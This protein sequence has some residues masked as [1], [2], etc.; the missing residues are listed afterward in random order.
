MP[1]FKHLSD[2]EQDALFD[3]LR[4]LAGASPSAPQPAQVSETSLRI[5]EHVIEGNCR[6]C[7]DATGPGAGQAGLMAGRIPSL[8]TM[9]D[10][11]SLEAVVHKVRT[12]WSGVANIVH[13]KSAMPVL[14]YLS[15]EEVAA[16]YLYLYY[17]PPQH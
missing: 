16:A 9:P 10:Q 8:N 17:Y 6:I 15:D 4:K 1:P 7:H 5:G 13:Q 11:L 12:G 14:S 2:T 3:F